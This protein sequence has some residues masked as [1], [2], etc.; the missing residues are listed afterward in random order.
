[1]QR[2]EGFRISQA[3]LDDWAAFGTSEMSLPG[4]V[5]AICAGAVEVIAEYQNRPDAP[6]WTGVYGFEWGRVELKG[7]V[8]S[9]GE[10]T[11]LLEAAV[12]GI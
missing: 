1:M 9:V 6:F 7:R 8:N 10:W 11:V 3:A 12:S 2:A 4:V 5:E